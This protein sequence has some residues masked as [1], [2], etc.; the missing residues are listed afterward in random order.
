MRRGLQ[1]LLLSVVVMIGLV[2]C[3]I[4]KEQEKVSIVTQT[5]TDDM[6]VRV[7]I[8]QKPRRIVSFGSSTDDI[9]ITLV[10]T[11]RIVAVSS[12]PSNL[13][14]DVK[15]IKGRVKSSTETILS[16]KPDLVVIPDWVS[17]H[18]IDEM[19]QMKLPVYV[20]KTPG[21][22]EETRKLILQLAEV[23]QEQE[24]GKQ[25]VEDIDRRLKKVKSLIKEKGQGREIIAMYYTA[26]GITGGKESTFQALCDEA[27]L[28]NGGAL[29]G[30]THGEQVSKEMMI[31]V[32]PD[33]IFL[34]SKV[35]DTD[36]YKTPEAKELYEE[37]AFKEVKAIR[38]KRVVVVDARW[39]MSYS[40][41]MVNAVEAMA[42]AAY[43]E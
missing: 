25:M 33:I 18:F 30:I 3:G 13:E 28:I 39:I 24:K 20:H 23:V 14:E 8:P 17:P 6:G 34:S 35:Y 19:R 12:V 42:E 1:I 10:G 43:E 40:Q 41:F 37:E 21:K 29:A 9:L 2:A 31:K 16:F 7:E 5:V 11:D 26:T 38:N 27:E 22:V 15:K 36:T 4:P 32:N